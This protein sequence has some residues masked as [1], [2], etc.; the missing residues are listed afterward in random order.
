MAVHLCVAFLCFVAFLIL[1]INGEVLNYEFVKQLAIAVLAS[2]VF[3]LFQIYIPN[4]NR[5][6]CYKDLLTA[7]LDNLHNKIN[8]FFNLMS[9]EVLEKKFTSEND[10]IEI[11]K[12]M[13]LDNTINRLKT[14]DLGSVTFGQYLVNFR[15]NIFHLIQ[16]V[17]IRY[18]E[19]LND[20]TLEIL[21]DLENL[22]L[23]VHINLLTGLNK[24][25]LAES[26][27]LSNP[28]VFKE[29]YEINSRLKDEL[30]PLQKLNK[31]LPTQ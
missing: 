20:K 2:G 23:F 9:I 13:K 24:T 28:Y 16:T 30:V 25:A 5:E 12:K 8:Q 18:P 7:E 6:K 27:F 26:N 3:Y 10:L 1:A 22:E 14:N 4:K 21:R 19:Y 15:Q 17:R 11:A 29:L 31:F